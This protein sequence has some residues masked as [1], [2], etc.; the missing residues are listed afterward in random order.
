METELS[1]GA[2]DH[3]NIIIRMWIHN[4]GQYAMMGEPAARNKKG[5]YTSMLL[6]IIPLICSL[7]VPYRNGYYI[8]SF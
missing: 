4:S 1:L 8:D 2:R 3:R 7:H 5:N 6:T